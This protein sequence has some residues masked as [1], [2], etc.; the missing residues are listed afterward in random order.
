MNNIPPNEAIKYTG[1]IYDL[2][3]YIKK[4]LDDFKKQGEKGGDIS[5]RLRL[6][7]GKE[8]IVTQCNLL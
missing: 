5:V 8:I 3:L 6:K 4:T 1:L 7:D 2:I